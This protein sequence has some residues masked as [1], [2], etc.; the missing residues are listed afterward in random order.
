MAKKKKSMKT[1]LER[2]NKVSRDQRL[3]REAQVGRARAKSFGG[4]PTPKQERK[5]WRK[6]VG[7]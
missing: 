4:K 3:A 7:E 2:M 1:T 6:E 5:N